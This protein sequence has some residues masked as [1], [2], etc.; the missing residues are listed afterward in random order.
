MA[1]QTHREVKSPTISARFLADYMASSA[2][3]QRPII[4]DCKYRSLARV[5]QHKEARAAVSRFVRAGKGDTAPLLRKA[6]ELRDRLTNTDF[7][8]SELDVNADYVARFAE[9]AGSLKLPAG[10]VV[11]PGPVLAFELR[12]VRVLPQIEIQTPPDNKDQQA[13]GWGRSA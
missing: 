8:R 4:T 13:S 3:A 5:L 1:R 9:V 11:A 12:G 6:A 10:E 2:T 7:E